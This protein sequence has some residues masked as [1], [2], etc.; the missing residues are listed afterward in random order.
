MDKKQFAPAALQNSVS[1]AAFQALAD[2][3][4][5]RVYGAGNGIEVGNEYTLLRIDFVSRYIKPA[6][7]TT[8]EWNAMSDEQKAEACNHKPAEWFEFV[9]NNGSLSFGAVFGDKVMYNPEFWEGV[10]T[11]VEDFDVNNIFK[12][13]A[14]TPEA[15]IKAGVDGLIGK[16][17]KCI[18]TKDFQRGAFD[19]KARAFMIVGK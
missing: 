15:W 9:T 10:E 18:G 3:K 7:L 17:I 5:S 16:T 1:D 2:G 12:P 19:A 11:K 4:G 14:R 8:E 6:D 13:S